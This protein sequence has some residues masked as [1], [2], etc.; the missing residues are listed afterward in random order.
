MKRAHL[1]VVSSNWF[2]FSGL[3]DQRQLFTWLE[4]YLFRGR[5]IPRFK[6]KGIRTVSRR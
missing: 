5:A 2:S 1:F 3:T 6:W 4:H